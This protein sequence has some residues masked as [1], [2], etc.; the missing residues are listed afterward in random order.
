[1]SQQFLN[2]APSPSPAPAPPPPP[3][4]AF[5]FT[6][7]FNDCLAENG[8]S[9]AVIASIGTLCGLSTGAFP[10]A[11]AIC[12][13]SSG[14]AGIGIVEMCL[15]RCGL[16]AAGLAGGPTDITINL[17]ETQ[18]R[19]VAM[20]LSRQLAARGISTTPGQVQQL[21]P[22]AATLS[23]QFAARGVPVTPMQALQGLLQARQV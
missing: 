15:F 10:V 23:Q 2:V 11:G 14:L 6:T 13:I 20:D 19:G 9:S 22:V 12:A 8:V 7:C 5:D 17:G 4:P 21:M 16:L 1:M 3:R 18:T